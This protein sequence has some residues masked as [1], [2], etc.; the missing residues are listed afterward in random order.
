VTNITGVPTTATAGTPLTLSGTVAPSN[1]TNQS[2]VWSVQSAGTTGAS[3]TGGNTLNT[4]AAGTV[5]V[6][7][8]IVNGASAT[9]NFTRNFEITVQ[10][11]TNVTEF[12]TENPLRAWTRNGLLHVTGLTVGET[13]SVYSATGAVVYHGVAQSETADVPLSVTGL[14]IVRNGGN[15]IRVVFGN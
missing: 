1:A 2:I 12:P 14:Y 8:T 4:T 13:L 6:T 3:I 11:L 10:R 9:T 5:T 7:A 15:T